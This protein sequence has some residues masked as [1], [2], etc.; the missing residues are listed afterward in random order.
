MSHRRKSHIK[1][2]LEL[3]ELM[4]IAGWLAVVADVIW[5]IK[6]LAHNDFKLSVLYLVAFI[7]VSALVILTIALY[8]YHTRQQKA[9]LHDELV[10]RLKHCKRKYKSNQRRN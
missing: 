9:I 5:V 4:S 8:K 6:D 10:T 1:S 3:V 7:L 2:G